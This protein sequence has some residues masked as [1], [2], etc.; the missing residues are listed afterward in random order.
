MLAF[1]FHPDADGGSFERYLIGHASELSHA[2]LL[3]QALRSETKRLAPA[4][5]RHGQRC[6]QAWLDGLDA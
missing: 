5:S 3:P 1:Q 4:A 2:G 6:L